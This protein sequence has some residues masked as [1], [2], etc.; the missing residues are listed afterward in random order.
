MIERR[1]SRRGLL[2][3][4]TFGLIATGMAARAGEFRYEPN[5]GDRWPAN[6]VKAAQ[7]RLA[8]RG[9]DPG[10]ADGKYG[11]KTAA[12]IRSFQAEQDMEPDGRI[13]HDLLIALGFPARG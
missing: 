3:L 1:F 6:V 12:A 13:T 7:R 2:G 4:A 8:A 11:P 5:S 10:P 9:H